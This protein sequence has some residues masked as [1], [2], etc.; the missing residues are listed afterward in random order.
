MIMIGVDGYMAVYAYIYLIGN[1]V[2]RRNLELKGPDKTG[3]RKAEVYWLRITSLPH[4]R[5]HHLHA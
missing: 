2:L 1:F 5:I 3:P 4:Q